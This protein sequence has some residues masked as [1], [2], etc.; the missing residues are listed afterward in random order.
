MSIDFIY[1][2]L[3]GVLFIDLMVSNR[4]ESFVKQ[5]GVPAHLMQDFNDLYD[6]YEPLLI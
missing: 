1:F 2:D 5:I 3:G 6:K 4:W